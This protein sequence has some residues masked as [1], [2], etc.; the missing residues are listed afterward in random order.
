MTLPASPDEG[1]PIAELRR[2]A[3]DLNNALG[4]VA[5]YAKFAQDELPEGSG[6]WA[7]IEHVRQAAAQAVTAARELSA[8][9]NHRR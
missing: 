7:D 4:V 1:P 3:H 6:P 9:A 5:N 8:L 2:I